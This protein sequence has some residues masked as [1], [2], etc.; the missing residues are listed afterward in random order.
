MTE[1]SKLAMAAPPS[2]LE[3][4]KHAAVEAVMAFLRATLGSGAPERFTSVSRIARIA[5]DLELEGRKQLSMFQCNIDETQQDEFGI[6]MAAAVGPRHIPIPRAAFDTGQDQQR[7]L[8]GMLASLRPFLEGQAENHRSNIRA[9]Q[10]AELR[11]LRHMIEEMGSQPAAL[12]LR[13]RANEL[14]KLISEG[15]EDGQVVSTDVLRGH[16]PGEPR[17]ESDGPDGPRPDARGEGG[18]GGA[19]HE[20]EEG[21]A[22]G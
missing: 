12:P 9:N 10:A 17:Q 1:E 6:G 7:T 19:R 4:A 11:D 2:A 21:Y 3:Q 5:H 8:Q 20:S 14:L 13:A 15:E 16:P 18:D 22:F